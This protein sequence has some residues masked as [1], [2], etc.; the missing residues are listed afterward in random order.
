V[1][2]RLELAARLFN[3]DCRLCPFRASSLPQHHESISSDLVPSIPGD[4]C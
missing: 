3:H 4:P 2:S 1:W